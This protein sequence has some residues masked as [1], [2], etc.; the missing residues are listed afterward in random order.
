MLD[1]RPFPH[2]IGTE[3]VMG[4]EAGENETI[5]FCS[6]L[7]G[8]RSRSSTFGPFAIVFQL[9]PFMNDDLGQ[10][11]LHVQLLHSGLGKCFCS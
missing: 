9:C 7:C 3:C 4:E 2:R 1:Q 11:I 8:V 10:Y 6:L 5:L